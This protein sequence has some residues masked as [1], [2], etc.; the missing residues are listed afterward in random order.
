MRVRALT[1]ADVV[2][3]I[4]GTEVVATDAHPWA[5]LEFTV[6]EEQYHEAD[7]TYAYRIG[8]VVG[9]TSEEM[10]PENWAGRY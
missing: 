8:D 6:D 3:F 5:R 7:M 10:S 1:G 4:D 9:E 2:V